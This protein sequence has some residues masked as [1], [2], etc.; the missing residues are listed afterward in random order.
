MGNPVGSEPRCDATENGQR[1]GDAD[2]SDLLEDRPQAEMGDQD[3]EAGGGDDGDG[4][5]R[6]AREGQLTEPHQHDQSDG[7]EP[8]ALGTAEEFEDRHHAERR[9]DQPLPHRGR[10]VDEPPEEEEPCHA[11]GPEPEVVRVTEIGPL[12]SQDEADS[13]DGEGKQ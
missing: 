5:H 13:E 6:R 9:R 8:L 10:A 12:Q 7:N 3:P 4:P 1:V 11:V 2:G